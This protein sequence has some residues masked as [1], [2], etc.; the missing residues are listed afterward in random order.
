M[1]DRYLVLFLGLFLLIVPAGLYANEQSIG[2]GF[3]S[4]VSKLEGDWNKPKLSFGGSLV[5]SYSPFPFWAVSGE[6]GLTRL[7]T[8]SNQD[9]SLINP[10]YNDPDQYKTL[11]M[12]F[13]LQ[14]RVYPFPFAMI[15][16]FGEFGVG[17]LWYHTT[18]GD[19]TV[20]IDGREEKKLDTIIKV[21]GGLEY[22]IDRKISVMLG[23]DYRLTMTDWLD[24]NNGGDENDGIISV[25][26]GLN[27]HFMLP[28]REDLDH[29]YVPQM[30]D[31]DP[32]NPE[33]SN[34]YLDHDG[35]PE[36]GVPE[37]FD[38]KKPLVK[39]F[40]VFRALEGSDITIKAEI[41]ATAPL[42]STS[43]MFRTFN[44]K[45][46]HIVKMEP[47][48]NNIY[49]GKI[50]KAYVH[51]EGLEYFVVAVTEDLKGMGYSGL[52]KRPI[53]VHVV[54]HASAWRWATGLVSVIGW[55]SAL[56]L[57]LRKQNI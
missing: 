48:K 49:I 57:I 44:E 23:A 56:F 18:Y 9:L 55:S 32:I 6:L 46:W 34:G 3:K 51:S 21:G 15:K 33:D 30:M 40:P 10:A 29:D 4:G 19:S 43:I 39:H 54:P 52:P 45:K 36:N 13:E 31:V 27:Y 22:R 28:D 14:M 11:A 26:A 41:Y 50:D 20:V 16:P 25:W 24:L 17:G 42:K 5:V 8:G 2:V 7:K 35:K 1:K 38:Y 47:M 12:P 37:N 53:Q